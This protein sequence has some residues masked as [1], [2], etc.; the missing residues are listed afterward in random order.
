MASILHMAR[1]A[2][3]ILL[4]I[5]SIV[6]LPIDLDRVAAQTMPPNRT[7]SPP[8]QLP[9]RGPG[10]RQPAPAAGLPTSKIVFPALPKTQEECFALIALTRQNILNVTGPSGLAARESERAS[11][12]NVFVLMEMQ[13]KADDY[14]MAMQNAR[15]TAQMLRNSLNPPPTKGK[16]SCDSLPEFDLTPCE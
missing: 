9:P 10:L 15:I 3:S 7:G 4:A 6:V 1:A 5:A 13:C 11:G 14:I 8:A 16:P 2:T 12:F